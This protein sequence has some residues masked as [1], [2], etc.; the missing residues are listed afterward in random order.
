MNGTAMASACIKKSGVVGNNLY[1]IY[2]I[3]THIYYVYNN[4]HWCN[5]LFLFLNLKVLELY[6]H[7]HFFYWGKPVWN[8]MSVRSCCHLLFISFAVFCG[9]W[10]HWSPGDYLQNKS[11]IQKSDLNRLGQKWYI[12]REASEA[13]QMHPNPPQ[14][15]VTSN[16]LATVETRVLWT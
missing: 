4:K 6:K 13:F 10:S 9:E 16:P 15:L 1:Y 11:Y 7:V 3:Y 5:N 8:E 12:L 14:C 2:I